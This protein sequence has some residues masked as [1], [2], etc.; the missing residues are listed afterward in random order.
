MVPQRD[1]CVQ[2]FRRPVA[3][4]DG[5]TEYLQKSLPNACK[6]LIRNEAR[7]EN[8]RKRLQSVELRWASATAATDAPGCWHSARTCVLNSAPCTRLWDLG[9]IGAHLF[10]WWATSSGAPQR[11]SGWDGRTLTNKLRLVASMCGFLTSDGFTQ[12]KRCRKSG[13]ASPRRPFE[14]LERRKP[15][16]RLEAHLVEA[17][18]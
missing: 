17:R 1:E 15:L 8:L 3:R 5:V 14:S 9:C 16:H 18:V 4:P 11:R 2:R 6:S 12:A 7:S 13:H 10:D